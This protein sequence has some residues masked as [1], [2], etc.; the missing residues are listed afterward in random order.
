MTQSE[1]ILIIDLYRIILTEKKFLL[2][3]MYM[4]VY[5]IYDWLATGV[6]CVFFFGYNDDYYCQY[7]YYCPVGAIGG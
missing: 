2:H 6:A 3:N 7:Y 1:V 4:Y 5:W